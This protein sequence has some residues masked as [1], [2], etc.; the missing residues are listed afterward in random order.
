MKYVWGTAGAHGYDLYEVSYY[1]ENIIKGF[2]L[3]KKSLV[4]ARNAENAKG[5][6]NRH[7]KGKA[8]AFSANIFRSVLIRKDWDDIV[9]EKEY[10]L[11]ESR[12]GA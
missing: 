3:L 1:L 7:F 2:P 8:N 4:W 10:A 11:K 9:F 6:I 5:M 12:Q